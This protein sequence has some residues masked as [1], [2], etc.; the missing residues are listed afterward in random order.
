MLTRDDLIQVLTELRYLG[1]SDVADHLILHWPG[2]VGQPDA[3]PEYRCVCER[4][5]RHHITI[6]QSQRIQHIWLC[7]DHWAA[8]DEVF[9]PRK[10]QGSS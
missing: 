7:D 2:I 1:P 4:V 8:L 10:A 3:A 6:Q 5:G 9:E